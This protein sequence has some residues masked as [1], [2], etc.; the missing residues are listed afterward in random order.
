MFIG[1]FFTKTNFVWFG[2]FTAEMDGV[3]CA[4]CE[5]VEQITSFLCHATVRH[6]QIE[7]T[8]CW[9]ELLRA[10]RSCTSSLKTFAHSILHRGSRRL[11]VQREVP[12]LQLIDSSSGRLAAWPNQRG[13]LCTSCAGILVRRRRR[14]IS[15]V[16]TVV[17]EFALGLTSQPRLDP[18]PKLGWHAGQG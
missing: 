6:S 18:P 2:A 17:Y 5:I 7:L 14:R 1:I 13:L 12:G 8:K 9:I 4:Y 3:F 15:A 10:Q 16:G 11:A